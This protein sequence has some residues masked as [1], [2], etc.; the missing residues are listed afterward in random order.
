MGN[1]KAVKPDETQFPHVDTVELD[2]VKYEVYE[3]DYGQCYFFQY[4][5]NG[6]L[7]EEGCGT[8]NPDYKGYIKD[9]H[10][11]HKFLKL[12]RL[13]SKTKYGSIY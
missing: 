9:F 5:E 12:Q 6:E 11:Y 3:D 13:K 4:E 2:G 7:H 1:R 8:Y 10:E